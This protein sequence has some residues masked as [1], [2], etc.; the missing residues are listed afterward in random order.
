M[1]ELFVSSDYLAFTSSINATPYLY[2]VPPD[3]A[4]FKNLLSIFGVRHTFG[5]SDFCQVL[6]RM[7]KEDGEASKRKIEIAVNLVQ[8]LSDDVMK[9]QQ[10]DIFAPSNEGTFQNAATMVYDDA[11]W[12]SKTLQGKDFVFIHQKISNTVAEKIGAKSLRR[13]LVQDNAATINFGEGVVHESFGQS[14]ALT[15]VSIFGKRSE[16]TAVLKARL[17]N[18]KAHGYGKRHIILR[19]AIA[20][21]SFS[22]VEFFVSFQYSCFF[23]LV[24]GFLPLPYSLIEPLFLSSRD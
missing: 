1:G 11:P 16:L 12:I 10:M 3:L 23:F 17:Q 2:T 15:R 6:Q 5:S 14:E 7:S 13:L 9:L 22:P 4:S 21:H 19:C 24:F 20:S 18:Q 8:S